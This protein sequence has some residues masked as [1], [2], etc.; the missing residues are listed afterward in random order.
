MKDN[1][2]A[3]SNTNQCK[4]PYHQPQLQVYGHLKDI[5][6]NLQPNGN[7]DS[8]GPLAGRTHA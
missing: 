2:Q 1:E 4:K 3:L 6:Q 7:V 8:L 5:T